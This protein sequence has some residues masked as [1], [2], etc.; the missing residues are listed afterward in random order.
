MN[1]V[2]EKNPAARLQKILY[3][4]YYFATAA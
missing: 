1:G 3:Q 4:I 2:Q